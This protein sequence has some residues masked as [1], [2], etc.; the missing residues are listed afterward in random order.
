MNPRLPAYARWHQVEAPALCI[1]P[2]TDVLG[3]KLGEVLWDYYDLSYFV[4]KKTEWSFQRFSLVY[5]QNPS[6]MSTDNVSGQFQYYD[7][8]PHLEDAALKKAREEG[9]VDSAGRPK[10]DKRAYFRKIILS[11][12]TASKP[13]E[14]AD[15]TVIQ[16]W[17]ETH[18]RRYYLLRQSR[19]KVD[20][21]SMIEAIERRPAATRSMRSWWRTRARAPPT[22]RRAA[23]PSSSAGSRRLRSSRSTPRASRRNSASTRSRR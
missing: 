10:P 22:S 12:D 16:T 13:T 19:L 5:Q 11:V 23:R 20:F 1:D 4:T 2:E 15:Y 21:N 18:D 7:T 17:G 8:P 14:R 3:R 6:A 9:H